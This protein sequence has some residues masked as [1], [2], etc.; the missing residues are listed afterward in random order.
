MI[1][2]PPLCF[3]PPRKVTPNTV[4]YWEETSKALK[5]M[6]DEGDKKARPLLVK[7][8]KF[9]ISNCIQQQSLT[10]W[11]CKSIKDYNKTDHQVRSIEKG[12]EC[13]C[14]G[15]NQKLKDLEEGRSDVKP[16]CSHILAVKQFIFIENYNQDGKL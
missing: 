10:S 16:I 15:Y 1:R 4:M 8:K 7:A 5:G 2:E 11:I 14:Q 13:D 3:E 6:Q 9:L 12:F